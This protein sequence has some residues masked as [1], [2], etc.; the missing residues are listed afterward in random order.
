MNLQTERLRILYRWCGSSDSQSALPGPAWLGCR[1]AWE[2]EENQQA[3][4]NLDL[5]KDAS[6]PGLEVFPLATPGSGFHK[7]PG[8]EGLEVMT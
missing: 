8:E 1:T 4:E 7:F 2:V 5:E 6:W 3:T